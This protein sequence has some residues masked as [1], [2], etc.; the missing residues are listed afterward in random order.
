MD[1]ALL[2]RVSVY[3][4]QGGR[5]YMEDVTEIIVEPEPGEDEPT[6]SES[7]ESGGGD[8]AVHSQAEVGH[9]HRAGEPPESPQLL[10]E[11]SEPERT[12]EP[13]DICSPST[14]PAQLGRSR[15]SVA[16]FAVFDGHGGR[17]AAQFARDYLWEFMKKQRGFWSDCDREVSSAIRKGFV[18]CHHA[19][20]KKLRK[21]TVTF[22]SSDIYTYQ[23]STQWC[24]PHVHLP[25]LISEE[26]DQCTAFLFSDIQIQMFNGSRG[27]NSIRHQS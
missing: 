14:P 15:R 1:N 7:E 9:P 13:A 11:T 21:F 2:M 25:V 8:C 12:E 26:M 22:P 18:A 17:E 23:L 19:M 20:W 24:S 5:R 3:T 4:D 10:H 6:S 27:L 16:F